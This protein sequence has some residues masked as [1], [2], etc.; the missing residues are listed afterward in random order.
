MGA[1]RQRRA[2][3]YILTAEDYKSISVV[4]LGGQRDLLDASLINLSCSGALIEFNS[5]IDA[6]VED[7]FL[8]EF[9]VP[10]TEDVIV[11]KARVA[12]V[13]WRPHQFRLG[14]EFV[15]LPE[16]FLSSLQ[17]GLEPKLAEQKIESILTKVT[18]FFSSKILRDVLLALLIGGLLIAGIFYVAQT[19]TTATNKFEFFRSY[20][21]PQ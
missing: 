2:D 3:R 9:K 4:R 15:D 1:A 18:N 13:D 20:T 11:W 7:P 19:R 6:N 12:R 17:T 21:P 10:A 16:A 5:R 14:L 8:L